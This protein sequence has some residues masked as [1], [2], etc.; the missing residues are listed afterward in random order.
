MTRRLCAAILL[1]EAVALGLSA[2]VLITVAGV[3]R[4]AGLWIG[5]G[6]AVACLLVS[7][8][9]RFAWSY[10]LGW[11]IQVAAVALGTQV[12]A[13]YVV[14]GI[15]LLLWGT[16]YFLG[17]RIER[18]GIGE[19]GDRGLAVARHPLRE[20][21]LL[22]GHDP[23]RIE[24]TGARQCLDRLV[25]APDRG[26]EPALRLDDPRVVGCERHGAREIALGAVPVDLVEH[27]EMA[28]HG[29]G[30]G[31]CAAAGAIEGDRPLGAFA[32]QP[33]TRK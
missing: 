33:R 24:T 22:H 5:L 10:V 21:K 8:L 3:G 1:L 16:S 2:P 17:R 14:G 13:M 25:V 12:D 20:T 27:L 23:P 11:A 15:F 32:C 9:L 18:R 29:Q 4:A 30:F 31:R 6:L 28:Q 19:R 26:E 7:G